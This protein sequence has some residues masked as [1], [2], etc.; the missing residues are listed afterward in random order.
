MSDNPRQLYDMTAEA[1]LISAI[2]DTPDLYP[3][4]AAVH[5]EDFGHFETR[6]AWQRLTADIRAGRAVFVTDYQTFSGSAGEIVPLPDFVKEDAR[7]ILSYSLSRA[8]MSCATDIA[9]A[10]YTADEDAIREAL[11]KAAT[12]ASARSTDT[13]VAYRQ[14]IAELRE[15]LENPEAAARMRVLTG[16]APLDGALGIERQTMTVV[17]AR[18]SMGKTS[19]L[20]QVSDAA[21]EA[22]QVVAVFSKEES[23]RQWARRISFRRAGIGIPEFKAGNLSDERLRR[24]SAE[25]DAAYG[26]DTLWLDSEPEQTTEQ[27]AAACEGL[28]A[29]LG[30]LDLV[31]VDHARHVKAKAD[32]EVHRMGKV[33]WGLK[34]LAK[35]L[36][37]AVIVAAQLSR[38]VEG[39]S[40]P[41]PDLK[42]LRDSGEIEENADNVIGLY[43]EKYYKPQ[44]E[45]ITAEIL[46]RKC[47]EGQRGAVIKLG[48]IEDTMAF[49]PLARTDEQNQ[50]RA[51]AGYR[52]QPAG[53]GGDYRAY[54][55]G[56]D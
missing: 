54:R 29:K 7:R 42:D 2:A 39:Q 44:T 45:D 12:I 43:R 51:T 13:L 31:L 46:V 32:N 33:T 36:N 53:A 35:R 38:A 11:S 50:Q 22:G 18:P 24:L 41:R 25:L 55:G 9:K 37:C 48:F 49:V 15:E 30:R 34:V 1:R 8:A 3:H 19:F 52:R 6:A 21:S 56:N 20:A 10:A 28:K 17:M 26:R 47:R 40:D 4:A 23:R 16:I 27:M 5:P 14:A